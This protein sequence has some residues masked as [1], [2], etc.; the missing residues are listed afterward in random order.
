MCIRDRIGI[1]IIGAA[2]ATLHYKNS[3]HVT[4]VEPKAEVSESGEIEDDEI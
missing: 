4:L 3:K 1:A 2:L